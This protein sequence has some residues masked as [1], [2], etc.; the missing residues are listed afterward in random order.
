MRKVNIERF[1]KLMN[2]FEQHQLEDELENELEY[3]GTIAELRG[4][5]YEYDRF[6]DN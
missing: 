1:E 6:N 4:R 5:Y 3:E 2:D